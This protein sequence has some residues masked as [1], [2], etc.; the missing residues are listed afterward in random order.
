MA[1]WSSHLSTYMSGILGD[2]LGKT[3]HGVELK[4]STILAFDQKDG[5]DDEAL[6]KARVPVRAR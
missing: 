4:H 1:K 6:A 2:Q 3:V 5:S